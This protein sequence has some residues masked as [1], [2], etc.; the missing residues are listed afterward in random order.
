MGSSVLSCRIL[1]ALLLPDGHDQIVGVV[2]QPD[3]PK[4]RHLAPAPS[5][6]KAL[7]SRQSIPILTPEQVNAPVSTAGCVAKIVRM[8]RICTGPLAL[9]TISF[10][11]R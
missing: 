10:M 4:G 7:L 3:R 1:E 6:V 2:T 5:P 9:L 11:Y 8:L